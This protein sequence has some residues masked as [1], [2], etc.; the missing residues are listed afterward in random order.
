MRV[1]GRATDVRSIDD[2]LHRERFKAILLD[3]D[4]SDA[5]SSCCVLRT[6]RSFLLASIKSSLLEQQA[7][8]RSKIDKSSEVV[9]AEHQMV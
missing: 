8:V 2:V 9:L 5:R 4:K 1:E 3:Q 6:R 7:F